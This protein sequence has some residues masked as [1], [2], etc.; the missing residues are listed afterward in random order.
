MLEAIE[1]ARASGKGEGP[2]T[3][4]GAQQHQANGHHRPSASKPAAHGGPHLPHRPAKPKPVEDPVRCGW[5]QASS[6]GA[7]GRRSDVLK[8][9]YG[10][11]LFGSEGAYKLGGWWR[12]GVAVSES[13][14]AGSPRVVGFGC[15]QGTPEQKALVAEVLKAKD[16]YEVLGI[17]KDATDDDIKKAYRKVGLGRGQGT[18]WGLAGAARV[19][20]GAVRVGVPEVR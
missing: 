12:R 16:F 19:R 15:T 4:A 5:Y 2:S 6:S 10:L 13:G 7:D 17:T 8:S 11:V 20:A 9:R 14:V 1:A 3:S 18:G